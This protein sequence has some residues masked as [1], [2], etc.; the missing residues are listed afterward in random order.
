M[1]QQKRIDN[2]ELSK[3]LVNEVYKGYVLGLNEISL[4]TNL[5]NKYR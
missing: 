2:T 4:V 5:L 3:M 1:P